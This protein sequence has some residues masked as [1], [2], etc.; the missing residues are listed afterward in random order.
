MSSPLNRQ[1]LLKLSLWAFFCALPFLLVLVYLGRQVEKVQTL[2]AD[3]YRFL[4]WGPDEKSLLFTHRA[5][6][7]GAATELLVADTATLE[8]AELAQLSSAETWRLTGQ[9]VDD[10]PVLAS[11]RDGGEMTYLLEGGTPKPI[12]SEHWKILSSQ[13]K[14]LF[15]VESGDVGGEERLVSMEDAPEI[16]ST[17]EASATPEDDPTEAPSLQGDGMGVGR[18]DRE[19]GKVELLFS[20]PFRG[21]SQEP[22][23]HMVCESPDQR[24]L[25]LVVGFGPAGRPGLWV[26]DSQAT[27]LLWTR[28]VSD[29]ELYGLAWSENSESLALTDKNG[30]V[31]LGN[32]LGVESTRFETQSLG[33]VRPSF[34]TDGELALIG[35]SSVHRLDRQQGQAQTQFDARTKQLEVLDFT[36]SPSGSEAAYFTAPKGYLELQ[37]VDLEDHDA[38]PK[39]LDLPGSA[40]RLAQGTLAYQVGEA[41]RS[42][43]R[44]WTGR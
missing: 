23:I 36:V 27:R 17:P 28:I 3:E 11:E 18:Y 40:R 29:S 16:S 22:H 44:F 10:L 1:R 34:V 8:F 38:A 41:I 31:V 33:E 30:L 9:F 35:K 32:V 2:P 21:K 12:P 26:Y 25:A 39:E 5:L 24:F 43:W 37:V 4:C 7:E 20:I 19:Q 6:K 14:G 15:F 13:G 42:A